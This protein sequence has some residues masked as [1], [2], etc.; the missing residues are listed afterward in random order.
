MLWNR[1]NKK[2][3]CTKAFKITI[4]SLLTPRIISL[5]IFKAGWVIWW[6]VIVVSRRKVIL[7][8]AW[9]KASKIVWWRWG[10]VER[11]WLLVGRERP[12]EMGRSL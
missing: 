2:N 1:I 10:L 7:H 5:S 9:W 3:R 12:S 8:K 11:R 4:K 6:P